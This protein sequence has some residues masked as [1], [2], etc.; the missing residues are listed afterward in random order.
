[1]QK[2][3]QLIKSWVQSPRKFAYEALQLEKRGVTLTAQ[4][5]G[6]FEELRKLVTAKIK[7]FHKQKL[8]D[9]EVLYAKKMG[10][11]VMSGQGTGKD[12]F[13]A[14]AIIW[15]LCCFPYPKIPCTANTGNQLKD[16]LWSEIN[17]WLRGS[18]VED[19]L[20]WQS[21]KIYWKEA[22]GKE[23]FAT[24]RTVNAK[25]SA[26]NQAE[27]LAGRHEDYMMVV[28]DEASGIPEPVFR[29]LE[30]GL[31]GVCNFILMV[32][33]PTRRTGF[34][35]DSHF[36]NRQDWVCLHWDAEKSEN[37]SREHVERYERK[38]G[39]DSNAFRIRVKGQPPLAEDDSLIPWDWVMA[40]VDKDI[41]VLE[42]DV[43]KI[44]LDVGGGGDP[45]ALC[46]RQGG[47]VFP[48]LMNNSPDTMEVTGWAAI[49][50]D[51]FDTA[52][53][54]VDSIGLGHGVYNRLK[55]L[56]KRGRLYSVD[57]RRTARD[58]DRFKKIR[59]ELWFALRDEFEDGTIDIPNDDVLIGE[60]S[61][62]KFKLDSSGKVKVEGKDELRT[63]GLESPNKADALMM[64]NYM[65]D[66][67]FR[68]AKEKKYQR[69]NNLEQE[70]T[71]MAA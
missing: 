53:T 41:E 6:G 20:V 29:P 46:R 32:F 3:T 21:E 15:F 64:T 25:A 67:T 47:K 39:R 51:E 23:W 8:T 57:V 22:G 42:D 24:A 43:R 65:K 9:E 58:Q 35:I 48:F 52:A 70:T 12:A 18:A 30:G 63:R 68:K 44:G 71:W 61:T 28:V 54:F 4:Q 69:K 31:T 55:E 16:V 2:E 13:A 66:K 26:D 17:K 60:L 14:M 50:M 1:M 38:Y 62:I 49:A 11:S 27:T 34:A 40:A 36:K 10:I 59:D 45:S 33:N 7:A 19:W 37:V 5:E 56:R